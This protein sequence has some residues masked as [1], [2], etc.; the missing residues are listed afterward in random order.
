MDK[1]VFL[2]EPYE[3]LARLAKWFEKTAK[4]K[5][6]YL[7]HGTHKSNLTSI[8]S[9]GL[10][11]N[12]KNRVWDEDPDANFYTPSRQSLEGIYLTSNLMTAY[13]A[14]NRSRRKERENPII[15]IVQVQ[16]NSLFLDED[17]LTINFSAYGNNSKWTVYYY[18]KLES[19]P[20]IKE[21]I[22][23]FADVKIGFI[24]SKFGKLHPG[25]K[26]R[27]KELLRK[28]AVA[29][30]KRQAAYVEDYEYKHAI[31]MFGIPPEETLPKPNKTEAEM[32]YKKYQ[33]LITRAIKT[34]AKTKSTN[35]FDFPNTRLVDN[36]A[37]SGNNKIV[38]VMEIDD[39]KEENR[40]VNLIYPNNY[41]DIP[42]EAL[43]KFLNDVKE[44]IGQLELRD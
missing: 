19:D 3:K 35:D 8:M 16:P 37:F 1:I 15:V 24:E 26:D 38:A 40:G 28:A 31:E 44:Q 21:E 12:P 14:A 22:E 43:Y 13:G 4:A 23:K 20:E 27:F 18:C 5:P 29:S 41:N 10:L 11:A 2:D 33:D 42:P 39:F 32:E 36:A 9:A 25:L 17:E 34:L 6:I 30:L 7:Y